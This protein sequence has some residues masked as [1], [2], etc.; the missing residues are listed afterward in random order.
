MGVRPA[1][2]CPSQ[3]SQELLVTPPLS[4]RS[5]SSI[6][7][8]SSSSSARRVQSNAASLSGNPSLSHSSPAGVMV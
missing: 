1:L 7:L 6:R 4:S 5:I 2:F 3:R 8:R